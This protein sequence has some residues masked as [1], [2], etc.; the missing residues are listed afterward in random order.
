MQLTPHFTLDELTRS[1]TAARL[2]I[3]NTPT[4]QVIERL[5]LLCVE[6]LEPA[7]RALGP[8]R[9]SSGFRSRALNARIPGSSDTSAHTLGWAADVQPLR[10]SKLDLARWIV[11]NRPFDQVILEFGTVQEPAWIHVSIDPRL[12]GQV[13]R[14]L[15]GKPYTPAKV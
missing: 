9:I 7:R 10:A 4:P 8:L 2:G 5:R 3:R 6:I 15:K 12:R 14:K 11:A 13:L 1:Q